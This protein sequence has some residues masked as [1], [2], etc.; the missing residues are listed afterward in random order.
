[1]RWLNTI[2]ELMDMNLNR[3]MEGRIIWQAKLQ[4]VQVTKQQKI[5]TKKNE[6][7]KHS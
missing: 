2:T 6:D 4:R 3:E 1:M 5:N 7:I